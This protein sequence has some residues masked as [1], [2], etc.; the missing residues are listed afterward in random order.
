MSA[1]ADFSTE[2][3]SLGAR[4]LAECYGAKVS[5]QQADHELQRNK[6]K[7]LNAE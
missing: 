3:L 2:G 7:D 6:V 5:T 1:I 4:T